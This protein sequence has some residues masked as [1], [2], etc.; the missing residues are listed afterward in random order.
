MYRQKVVGLFV[1]PNGTTLYLQHPYLVQKV[2]RSSNARLICTQWNAQWISSLVKIF[3]LLMQARVSSR[4]GIRY[5]SFQV[6]AFSFQ[7]LTQKRRPSF[8]F[9]VKRI[10]AM[11]RAWLLLINPLLRLST[12][13]YLQAYSSSRVW[14]C[15]RLNLRLV[16]VVSSFSLIFRLQLQCSARISKAALEKNSFRS[17]N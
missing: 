12:R 9:Q 11:N 13:Y 14:C 5:Q 2:V 7:Q 16:T 4:R 15:S 6:I 8:A 17:L 1:S 10:E 3:A